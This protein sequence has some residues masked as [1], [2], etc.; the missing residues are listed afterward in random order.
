MVTVDTYM[1][2]Q[3]VELFSLLEAV[4]SPLIHGGTPRQ[5]PFKASGGDA[6]AGR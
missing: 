4:L 3:I 6:H 2:P 5:E 1:R